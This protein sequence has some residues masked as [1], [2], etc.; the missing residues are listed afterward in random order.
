MRTG[1]S[2]LSRV[3]MCPCSAV[4]LAAPIADPNWESSSSPQPAKPPF[5]LQALEAGVYVLPRRV[6]VMIIA[7]VNVLQRRSRCSYLQELTSCRDG[8]DV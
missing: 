6:K 2:H 5:V 1:P 8:Y 4:S 7:G 3:I